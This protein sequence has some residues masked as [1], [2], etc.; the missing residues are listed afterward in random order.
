M[1]N[2][3]YDRPVAQ[4]DRNLKLGWEVK[5]KHLLESVCG[6][7]SQHF[8]HFEEAAQGTSFSTSWEKLEKMGTVF[9]AAK[10]DFEGGYLSSMRSLVQAE[11]FDSE[12]EQASELLSNG[13]RTASAVVAGTVLETALRELCDRNK[14][15]RGS[16]DR[17][18]ADLAKQSVYNANMAKRI[19]ALAGIRNSGAH[20]KPEEFADGDVR[21]MIDDI[22][23]FLSQHLE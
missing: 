16:M 11:V 2:N 5:V 21:A 3:V 10:E 9:L 12:L 6:R 7:D 13:Y 14:I 20:G 22:A 4:V 8:T 18:N 1:E 23:R 17:M 19:T 15:S